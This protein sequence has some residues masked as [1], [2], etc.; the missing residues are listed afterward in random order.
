MRLGGA[1]HARIRGPVPAIAGPRAR[2]RTHARMSGSTCAAR[3]AGSS[4]AHSS[5]ACNSI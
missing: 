4:R 1:A 3:T 2:C 5:F